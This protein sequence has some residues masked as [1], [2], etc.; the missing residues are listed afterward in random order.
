MNIVLFKLGNNFDWELYE[1]KVY[2]KIININNP[3]KVIWD[4]SEMTNIPSFNIIFTS[5]M[6]T[7]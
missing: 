1:K 2:K 3:V 7:Y 6:N 4:L 5:V